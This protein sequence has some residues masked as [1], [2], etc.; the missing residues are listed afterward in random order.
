MN[1]PEAFKSYTRTLMGAELYQTLEKGLLEDV[2]TS[3][4]INPF[5]VSEKIEDKQQFI[6]KVPWCPQTG[7][8]LSNRHAFTFDPWLHAGMYY[9]QE[10]ASM[11]VDLVVRQ[12][13]HQPVM[14]LDLCAAP[15]GKSTALRS[16]LPN[17]SLLFSNEPMHTRAQILT[18]NMLKFGHPD[19]VV[20]NNYPRDYNKTK[21]QFDL[22]LADVPCSG[23]GMFRKDEGAI[24]EWSVQNVDACWRLQREIITDIWNC[25]KPGGILI[26][27][28]CT[29]NAHEDEENVE[30]IANELGAELIQI[31][32]EE[33]WNITGSLLGDNPVYRFIPGK[34]R[35]EGLFLSVLRKEGCSTLWES[36][37][38]SKYTK[39]E[40]R[41]KKDKKQGNIMMP[42]GWVTD[43]DEY[44]SV[45]EGDGLYAIHKSWKLEYQEAKKCLKV[46]HAGIKIGTIKGKDLIPN[47]S[48]AFSTQLNKEAFPQVELSYGDAIR[49]LRKEAIILPLNTPRGYVLVTYRDI[50]LGFE[51]NIGNRANNLYPAEWKIKSSHIP[52]GNHDLL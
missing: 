45:L 42:S 48:L 46:L 35:S 12:L 29:F 41:Q 40:N 6:A 8:F 34:T 47:Q 27:S 26:Y 17:G 20:T 52:E 25:L 44:D 10:A 43:E 31:E 5:K 19:V 7:R 9:V 4:R 24:K 13:V 50:P 51:K 33:A 36:M 3:I 18:E 21:L 2:P 28:T 39:S 23:E 1:L 14:A 16:A 30:W 38:K 32:T 49:Y 11:F 22:I 15:G 37:Q